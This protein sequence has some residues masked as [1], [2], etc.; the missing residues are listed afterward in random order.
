VFE[1]PQNHHVLTHTKSAEAKAAITKID[2]FHV[3][4]FADVVARMKAVPEGEGTLLDN[5]MVCMG[6]GISDGGDHKYSNLQVLLAG[7]AAGALAPRGHLRYDGE[8]PLADLWLTLGRAAGLKQERFA[9]S[10]GVLRELA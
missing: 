2:R 6:S 3:Q 8:R 10:K 4:F 5:A 1:K 9:D 7:R